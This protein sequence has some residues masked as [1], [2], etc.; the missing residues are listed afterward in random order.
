P[1]KPEDLA[2]LVET[3]L[4]RL[5]RR[6]EAFDNPTTAYRSHPHPDYVPRYSDYAHLARVSEWSAAREEGGE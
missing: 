1:R 3:S 2:D 5:R 6:I 4:D